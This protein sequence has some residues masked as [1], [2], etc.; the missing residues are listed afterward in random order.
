LVGL[1]KSIEKEIKTG[2]VF[3]LGSKLI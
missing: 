3:F 2:Q 1:K